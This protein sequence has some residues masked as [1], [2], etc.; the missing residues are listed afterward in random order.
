M[1]IQQIEVSLDEPVSESKQ[2]LP[3]IQK[4]KGENMIRVH[5]LRATV[6]E[7]LQVIK[8][9]DLVKIGIVGESST[10]KT[11]LAG[12][13][14]HLIHKMS[15]IPFA[16]KV[17]GEDEFLHIKETLEALE[18]VNYVMYF[19][20]LSFLQD[21]KALEEVKQA[22]TKIRHLK[23]DVK[24]IL[25]YDYHY[26][27]GLDKFLRQANFRFFTSIGSSEDDNMAK[28]VGV[29]Y[30]RRIKEFQQKYVEMTT[31]H[32]CT[33]MIG[34]NKYFSY[35][36]MNPF[37]VALFWNNQNL[38]YTIF[39]KREWIDPVCS[40]CSVA[41]GKIHHSEIPIE[42]F[43]DESEQKFTPYVFQAAVK[44]KSFTQGINVYS[45]PVIAALRYLDRALE[46][47]EIVLDELLV[48]YGLEPKQ[49]KLRKKL[50]GVLS[51]DKT[52]KQE[53]KNG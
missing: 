26:T 7:V 49:V 8:V 16:V 12:T 35:N 4:W 21:K 51:N 22:I 34:K 46:K 20:D 5:S 25:I 48:L 24:I 45:R 40:I 41:S 23:A 15:D 29:Q 14:M 19:H 3:T 2:N 10:G 50:D 42:K 39:P 6:K 33:F 44:L 18:P 38:R 47:K 30:T 37:V 28:I 17:F 31:K 32:K 36:Y 1:P 9:H 11:T 27:L 43:K 52:L 53:D 13:V